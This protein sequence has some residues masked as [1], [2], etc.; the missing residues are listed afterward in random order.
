MTETTAA[1]RSVIDR[2]GRTDR[3]GPRARPPSLDVAPRPDGGDRAAPARRLLRW[4]KGEEHV[5]AFARGRRF[6][7]GR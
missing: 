1:T 3:T 5:R 2:T 4:G 6:G 7:G